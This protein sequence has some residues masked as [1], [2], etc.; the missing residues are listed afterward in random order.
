MKIKVAIAG[1]FALTATF[2]V[3]PAGGAIGLT[4][5]KGDV[6][7]SL[8]PGPVQWFLPDGTFRG[9]LASTI[10][11]TGEGMRFDAAG[12]LYV[13]RWC[14]DL[15]PLCPPPRAGNTV[16][17]FNNL[18]VSLGPVGSGYDCAPHAIVF[19]AAGAAY[20]GQ[21][22][23]TGAVLKFAPT[24]D[25]PPVAYGVAPEV[26]GSF[27][28]DL[29]PDGCTMFYT[30]YG[31]NVK[32]FD[33]CTGTQLADFNAGPL[34][35]GVTHDLRVLPDL[36][37][38]VA[39]GPFIARLDAAGNL[40]RTYETDGDR[41]WTGVDLGGDGTFWAA[42]YSMSDIYRFD[43]ATGNVVTHFNTRTPTH[44]AVAVVVKK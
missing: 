37:I 10:P 21:A 14:A 13:T 19:D 8:E 23:C 44:T 6:F 7:V 3:S 2:L 18:G 12:N 4:F 32:R 15:D 39:N 36:G 27:W 28:I 22:G 20:V 24:F 34:P 30:S 9:F 38:L 25:D 1:L 5:A 26:Q 17:M 31:P 41:Y 40:V 43:L 29:A 35:G 16:E 11:G 33:V 42:D